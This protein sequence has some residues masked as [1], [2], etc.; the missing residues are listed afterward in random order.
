MAPAPHTLSKFLFSKTGQK[1][2]R[3]PEPS[4]SSFSLSVTQSATSQGLSASAAAELV[5]GGIQGAHAL[6]FTV[7]IC[8]RWLHRCNMVHASQIHYTARILDLLTWWP[9]SGSCLKLLRRCTISYG[10]ASHRKHR[11]NLPYMRELLEMAQGQVRTT[12]LRSV[13]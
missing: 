9:Y 1:L 3:P 5:I 6:N 13:Q 2:P 7:L 10:A 4:E 11:P 8:L 12:E